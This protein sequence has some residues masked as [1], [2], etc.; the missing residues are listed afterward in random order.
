MCTFCDHHRF[1][2]SHT[3]NRAIFKFLLATYVLLYITIG[4]KREPIA[5]LLIINTILDHSFCFF[6]QEKRILCENLFDLSSSMDCQ[7]TLLGENT[8]DNPIERL[9]P[10]G[11]KENDMPKTKLDGTGKKRRKGVFNTQWLVDAAFRP[12]LREYKSDST[13]ALCIACNEQFSVHNGGKNDI[14]RHMNSKKHINSMKVFNVDRNLITSTIKPVRETEETAA[15]EGTL[16]YHG[17]KHG[18]SYLSQQCTTNVMKS[19]FSSSSSLGKSICCGRTKCSP[20][21]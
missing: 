16:V 18:H 6:S 11:S 14:D 7:I 17:V 15:A 5:S 21:L 10:I 8:D 4:G 1:H 19:I 13:K 12:F 2:R 20:L 9:S 3:F